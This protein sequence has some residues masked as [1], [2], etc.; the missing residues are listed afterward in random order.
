MVRKG[1]LGCIAILLLPILVN[2]QT[3]P[4]ITIERENATFVITNRGDSS[5]GARSIPFLLGCEED[6]KFLVYY[7]PG[8]RVETVIDEYTSIMSTVVLITHSKENK[9]Q[10]TIQLLDSVPE[11]GFRPP[12]VL[13]LKEPEEPEVRLTQGHTTVV[14]R[15]LLVD[16]EA[17]VAK[18]KGPISLERS[19]PGS[20]NSVTAFAD[21]LTFDLDTNQIVMVGDVRVRAGARLSQADRLELNET[22]GIALLAGQ[23]AMSTEGKSVIEGDIIRYYL[24]SNEVIALGNIRG[25]FEINDP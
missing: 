6:L 15:F 19:N 9:D 1:G 7:G 18:M 25:A 16:Q 13:S 4:N 2:G 17:T 8:R 22:E 23:P 11:F 3:F 20:G 21:E 10:E 24:D 12:C 14:G 5:G